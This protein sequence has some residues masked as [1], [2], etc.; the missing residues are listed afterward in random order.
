MNGENNRYG[1]VRRP[2]NISYNPFDPLM[3]QNNVCYKCNNLGHK[4]RDCKE[5]KEDNRMPN[6]HIYQ[7]QHGKGKKLHKMKTVK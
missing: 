1:N 7:L 4:A 5:M 6:V 2:V 3:D